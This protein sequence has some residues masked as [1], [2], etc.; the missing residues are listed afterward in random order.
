MTT[1][2]N[3][4]Q[5][6]SA[7]KSCGGTYHKLWCKSQ[8]FKPENISTKLRA[9]LYSRA[10]IQTFTTGWSHCAKDLDFNPAV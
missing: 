3:I 8:P 4:L 6:S 10:K 1:H 2:E 7:L 5:F 9:N